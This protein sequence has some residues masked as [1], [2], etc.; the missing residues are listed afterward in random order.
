ML[1]NYGVE[2]EIEHQV[3][4]V[5]MLGRS[6][7]LNEAFEFIKKLPSSNSSAGLWGTL[8]SACNYHGELKLGRKVSEILFEMD[9]QNVGYYISLSNM[10]VAIGSWKDATELRQTIQD[11]G[12][13]KTVAYSLIDAGLG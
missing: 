12:L 7:R 10:Y 11:Q 13:R 1:E 8:L 2:T 3:Y 6:G 5:D 4:V 9:P